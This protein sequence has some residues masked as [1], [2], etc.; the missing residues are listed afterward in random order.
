MKNPKDIL[1]LT[2]CSR[3]DFMQ[4]ACASTLVCIASGSAE[5]I[6]VPTPALHE[7]SFYDSLENGMVRCRLCPKECVTSDGQ[8]GFCRVRENRKGRYFTLVHGAP[9]S[10]NTDPIEKKPFF[11]VYPGSKAFSIATVGCNFSCKFCQNWEISQASPGDIKTPFMPPGRIV[12]AALADSQKPRTVAYT[13][14]EPTIFYEYMTDC[15][16]AV[17]EAGLENIVVS[18]GYIQKQPL[19]D[20]CKTVRAIKI[21]FKAFSQKFYSEICGGDLQP[22]LD[23]LKRIS[24]SGTWLEIVTLVIPTLNDDMDEIKRMSEWIVKELGPDVPVHFTRFHPD[25]KLRNLPNT[26]VDTLH[27][28]RIIAMEQGCN[29]V[30]TGNMPGG[31]GEKTFCPK[32]KAVVI[33]RYGMFVVSDEL[34]K[35]KCHKCGN[36]IPGVWN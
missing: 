25:Y 9:C 3:R 26:P 13:Y 21:D 8:R 5:A 19:E 10:I 6:T 33:H 23:T 30:Y 22:V 16:R 2:P 17:K 20:L 35:G 29:F 15:A 1:L 12:Q 24:D 11:H 14:S 27:R 36:N 7:A 18:N 28:A 31:E 32:C 4:A 34:K